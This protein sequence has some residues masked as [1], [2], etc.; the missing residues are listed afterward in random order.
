MKCDCCLEEMD[1]AYSAW[2][3]CYCSGYCCDMG[4]EQ[5]TGESSPSSHS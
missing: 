2:H 3:G 4:Y 5:A 1:I